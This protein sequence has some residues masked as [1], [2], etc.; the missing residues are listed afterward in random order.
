MF[1]VL[2]ARASHTLAHHVTWRG[3]GEFAV[4]FGLIWIAWLNG[5]LYHDLHGREDSRSHTSI[6]LQ[7]MLLAAVA[8]FAG[9]AAGEDGSGFAIVYNGLLLVLT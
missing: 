7:M 2:I 5:T 1:V 4:I 8:V 3:V 9:D 6:F